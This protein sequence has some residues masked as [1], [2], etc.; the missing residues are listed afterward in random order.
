MTNTITYN[1]S[2][3]GNFDAKTDTVSY[4]DI[5]KARN[6]INS[7]SRLNAYN[8]LDKLRKV[9]GG[10]IETRSDGTL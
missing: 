2:S 4:Y 7:R 5:N 1:P 9:Y 3:E 10:T 8:R 6:E